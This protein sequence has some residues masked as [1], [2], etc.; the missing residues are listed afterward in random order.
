[1]G[2]HTDYNG[3][4]CLPIALPH[5][6][7]AAVRPAAGPAAADP[8]GPGRDG[9]WEGAL[10]DVGPGPPAGWAAYVAGVP[11]ALADLVGDAAARLRRLAR[12][13]RAARRRA[14]LLGRAGVRRR[15]SRSTTWLGLGL[16]R[17]GRGPGPARRRLRP[18][19]ERRRPRTDRRHGPGRLAALHGRPRPAARLPRRVG[20]AGAAGPRRRRAGLAGHRHPGPARAGRRP[21]RRAP[22]HLRGGGR[23][24]GREQPARGRRRPSSTRRWTGCRTTCLR[25]RVRH[26]VTE[27]ERVREMVGA[28]ARRAGGRPRAGARRLARLDARRLRDLLPRAGPRGRRRPCAAGALGRPDDRRRVRR[29]GDRAGAGRAARRHRAAV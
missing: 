26:V 21:V 25:R 15:P 10:D 18:G 28:A 29:L 13:A 3:G 9:S 4:L 20:R 14:V 5:R 27:I 1:M 19:R 2:E 22:G 6:T 16:R 8:F 11:W 7:F 12:R 17:L 24:L 23:E